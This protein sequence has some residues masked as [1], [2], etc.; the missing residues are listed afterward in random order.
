MCDRAFDKTYL[1]TVRDAYGQKVGGGAYREEEREPYEAER[2]P[3][4]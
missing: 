1:E 2:P 3:G 4:E